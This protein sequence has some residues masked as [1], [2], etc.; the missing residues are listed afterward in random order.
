MR[1]WSRSVLLVLAVGVCVLIV[2]GQTPQQNNPKAQASQS[3]NTTVAPNEAP[4]SKT[5]TSAAVP[6]GQKIQTFVGK[7]SDVNCGPRHFMLQNATDAECTRACFARRGLYALVVGD[8]VYSLVNQPGVI[9]NQ[10][11]G[12]QARVTGSLMNPDT[13][14]IESVGPAGGAKP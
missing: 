13:I 3:P 7:V 12:K 6:A 8:K 11:A 9:L 2:S 5:V 4:D 1:F 10:L 14:E